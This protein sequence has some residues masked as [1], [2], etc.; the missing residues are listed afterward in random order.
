MTCHV[1]RALDILFLLQIVHQLI[2]EGMRGL[3]CARKCGKLVAW[4]CTPAFVI[5]RDGW[6]AL[7]IH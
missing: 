4:Q 3:G 7:E 2:V 5:E 6:G 1:S